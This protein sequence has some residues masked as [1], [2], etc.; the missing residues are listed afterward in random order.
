MPIEVYIGL[1]F[2]TIGFYDEVYVDKRLGR[3]TYI[4][5]QHY[6]RNGNK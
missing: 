5:Y 1:H 4:T 2:C 6:N 3:V